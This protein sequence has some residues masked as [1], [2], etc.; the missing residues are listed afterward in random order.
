MI[1]QVTIGTKQ[2]P[3][4]IPGN[5]TITI[6]GHTN[7]P[8]PRIIC[9]VEQAEHHNLLLGIVINWCMAM[10]KA[11]TIPVIIINTNRYNVW[12]R[13]PLLADELFDMECDEI[14][15]RA[16]MNWEGNNISVGF[17]PVP[18]LLI[19]TNSCQVEAGPIQPDV[20]EME[21]PEF[22]PRPDTN[23]TDFDFKNELGWLPF[24]LNIGKEA[25]LTQDQQSHFI[26]LVYDNKEVFSL[27]DEDL[28]YS[29]LMK[30][31]IPTMTE[32]PVY[33]PHHTIPRQ[34][35]GE[36][37]KCLDTWLC[38][39][40]IRPSKSPYAS[41]VVRVCK[42][43][44]EI[45]L[46]INYQKLNSI[47]VR[48]T[49]PLPRIDEV[50]QVVHSS[51]WFTSVDFAQGYLQLAMEEGNIQKTAFRI[52][53]SGLYEFTCMPFGLSNAGSSFCHLMEQCLGDQQFITLLLYLDD[54]C[55]FSPSIEEMLDQI[56]LVFNRLK[57]FH[58]KIK[59][60]KCH[61]FDTSVLFLGHV[62]SSEGISMNPEKVEKV[63]DWPI[64]TNMKEV[65]SFLGLASYYQRFIPKFAKIAQCLHELVGPTSNKH[66]KL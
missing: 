62:L 52:G 57:E 39:G 34:L 17:Q 54:I 40:I 21:K 38:K 18:P 24:Q 19:D 27:H 66:K 29:D 12:I 3:I 59:P 9:L 61:F 16:N 30:H 22:G 6:L 46:C 48:D 63:Q 5:S 36:V 25:K 37:H 41:Q 11:R 28:G 55:I 53:S 2:Q 7:K 43:S 31:T 4:C 14:E 65:H 13:Q 15:Y 26:N 20:P 47:M 58:L 60:K 51:N 64:P 1:G 10:P 50:L 49:F 44:G 35:Q 32:K 23:S 33:L 8:P 42:K 45:C 56:E